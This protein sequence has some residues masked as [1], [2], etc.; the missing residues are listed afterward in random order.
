MKE[1]GPGLFGRTSPFIEVTACRA[2]TYQEFL[3]KAAHVGNLSTEAGEKELTL[4]KPGRGCIIPNAPLT[5]REEQ[6][7]WTLGNYLAIV[8][9]KPSEVK[10][11]VGYTTPSSASFHHQ[12][13]CNVT[14]KTSVK[15]ILNHT[16]TL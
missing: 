6:R 5:I 4:F 11:G 9:K 10:L 16:F 15:L 3:E 1:T 13:V 8:K 14:Y 7:E 2:D 12:K